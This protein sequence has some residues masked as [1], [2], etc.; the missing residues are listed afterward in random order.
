MGSASIGPT[1]ASGA[2]ESAILFVLVQLFA[3]CARTPQ[4][5]APPP[6]AVEQPPPAPEDLFQAHL[7]AI[8][9]EAALARRGAWSASG[10]ATFEPQ[11]LSV[12]FSDIHAP[13]R[14]RSTTLLPGGAELSGG[15]DGEAGWAISPGARRT[16][17]AELEAQRHRA[18]LRVDA[19][20]E[21]WVVEARTVGLTSVFDESRLGEDAWEVALT[22]SGGRQG[23]EWYALDGL[24]LARERTPD[25]G[26]PPGLTRFADYADVGGVLTPT[27]V[28]VETT[29]L[30]ITYRLTDWS[31]DP[32]IDDAT[33]APPI[34]GA[35]A[36]AS[37]PLER[38]DRGMVLVPLRFADG[39]RGDFLLD[40]GAN[41]TLVG[42]RLAARLGL[43]GEG[44]DLT[45]GTAGGELSGMRAR[46]LPP[47]TLGG[48]PYEGYGA[49]EV[50]LSSV[51]VDGVLGNDFLSLHVLE[52]DPTSGHLRLHPLD[53][54][55]D[56]RGLTA[57]PLAWFGDGVLR[58][59]ARLD[60]G[61]EFPM[62]VDL[63]AAVSVL[64]ERATFVAAARPDFGGFERAG[65]LKG[66][67]GNAT[68][69]RSARFQA[70][71]FGPLEEADPTLLVSDLPGLT[72]LFGDR[73]AG[74]LGLDR[75]G[76]RRL[77]L[78]P[79]GPT[80]YLGPPS[81]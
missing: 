11:D 22:W 65:A 32:D 53:Q 3:G 44:L 54:P 17:G 15:Y 41:T 67:A 55:P 37:A 52:L 10:E 12:S 16:G 51:G 8:G 20:W 75:L 34:L 1:A 19:G 73:A 39:E 66:A 29:D 35:P 9:G 78:D 57:L 18:D 62:L 58:V 4:P 77:V 5:Q 64:N 14:Y 71:T 42:Q 7:T 27:R 23:R 30:T 56:T 36:T 28:V 47:F 24:R 72:A 25:T 68:P 69:V 46:A 6:V 50:D 59:P 43:A 70:L 79:T 2:L 21:R 76:G 61:P 38:D 80:L 48:R 81:E 63:G 40:T 13:G 49:L 45:G 31:L 74:I 60:G 26:N 33:F